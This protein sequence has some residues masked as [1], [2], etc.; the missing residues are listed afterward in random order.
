[1]IGPTR[2]RLHYPFFPY[3]ATEGSYQ[4]VLDQARALDA[5]GFQVELVSWIDPPEEISRRL[6]SPGPVPFPERVRVTSFHG[7]SLRS[8]YAS[9]WS[10]DTDAPA[11]P[12]PRRRET[13]AHRVVRVAQSLLSRW[14]SPEVFHYPPELDLRDRLEQADVGVYHYSFAYPWLAARG[15]AE[16]RAV[17]H[18]HNLESE[19]ARLR[20]PRGAR[21]VWHPEALV[22]ALNVRKL[23]RHEGALRGLVDELWFVSAS[24]LETFR[25]QHGEGAERLVPPTFDPTLGEKRRARFDVET[26]GSR[27]LNLGFIGACHFEPNR[28]SLAWI[29]EELAPELERAGFRGTIL[30]AGKNVP[31]K[32]RDQARRYDFFEWLGFVP[33]LEE[34]WSRLSFLLMPQRGGSGIRIKLLEALASGVPVLANGAALQALPGDLREHALIS[35]HEGA[36]DWAARIMK[37]AS[38]GS[39]RRELESAPLSGTS[40]DAATTYRFLEPSGPRARAG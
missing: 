17:V 29:V 36:A 27:T 30:V 6:R 16:R 34:F 21:S 14:A 11:L 8:G 38:N 32:L 40:L 23:R 39:T 9:D 1:M 35:T 26:N 2:Y 22:H 25:R 5:A 24:D 31:E 37:E 10:G 28:L 15:R 13:A 7:G 20:I 18:F 33:D 4:V 19:L 12:L 3:P